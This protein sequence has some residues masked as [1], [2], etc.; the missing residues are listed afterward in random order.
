MRIPTTPSAAEVAFTALQYLPMPTIVLSSGKTVVLANEAMGKLLGLDARLGAEE[1]QLGITPSLTDVIF[2]KSLSQL[3]IDMLHGGSPVW[4]K[5][6]VRNKS[7]DPSYR[8]IDLIQNAGILR[9]HQRKN[10]SRSKALTG[11]SRR[12]HTYCSRSRSSQTQLR[13]FA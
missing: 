6:E 9:I 4:V 8:N 5:W 7:V 10:N 11:D 1:G 12:R 2:G 3:G 13:K